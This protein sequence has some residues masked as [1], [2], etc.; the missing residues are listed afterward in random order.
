M[1]LEIRSVKSQG[2]AILMEYVHIDR[3]LCSFCAAFILAPNLAVS[4]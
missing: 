3:V 1:Y 4:V 2:R